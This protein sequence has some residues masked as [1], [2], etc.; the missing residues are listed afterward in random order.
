MPQARVGV[1][2]GRELRQEWSGPGAETPGGGSKGGEGASKS[3]W[4]HSLPAIRNTRKTA[5]E[6]RALSSHIAQHVR[7]KGTGF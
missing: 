5:T 3:F 6:R 2:L 1:K 7:R 4:G